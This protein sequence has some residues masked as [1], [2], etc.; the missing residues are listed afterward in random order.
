M[1]RKR[2]FLL[3]AIILGGYLFFKYGGKLY[4]PILKKLKGKETVETVKGKLEDRVF[5]RLERDLQSIGLDR[6]PE[7]ISL[8]R[9]VARIASST[10]GSSQ[11]FTVVRSMK[12]WLG[13]ASISTSATF[14]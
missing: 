4:R 12:T 8:L 5:Q 2:L 14:T 1:Y 13:S 3:L 7:K 10:Q 9:P 6:L 11:A